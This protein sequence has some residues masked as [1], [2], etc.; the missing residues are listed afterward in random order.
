[1]PIVWNSGRL[2]LLEPS[3]P[4]Q[5]FNSGIVNPLLSVYMLHDPKVNMFCL[6]PYARC[7][8]LYRL[9]LTTVGL[10]YLPFVATKG[11]SLTQRVVLSR[12]CFVVNVWLA[13]DSASMNVKALECSIN[14]KP[15]RVGRM[16]E[17]K[18]QRYLGG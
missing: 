16:L 8:V 9:L 18:L 1:M 6:K 11:K 12:Y 4:V 7:E 13:F 10:K 5:G 15:F 14:L 3:G 17:F 2:N